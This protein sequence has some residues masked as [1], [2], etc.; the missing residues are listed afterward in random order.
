MRTLS[1]TLP[2]ASAPTGARCNPSSSGRTSYVTTSPL[3][4][5]YSVTSEGPDSPTR[6]EAFCR[7]NEDGVLTTQSCQRRGELPCDAMMTHSYQLM[8]RAGRVRQGSENVEDGAN[9]D[10]ASGR[11][12]NRI[13]G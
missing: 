11:S 7:M 2:P 5:S 4:A 10:L 13:A 8:A 6:Q 9:T 1:S 3:R 12:D